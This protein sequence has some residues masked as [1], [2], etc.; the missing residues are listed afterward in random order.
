MTVRLRQVVVI[1]RDL[2]TTLDRLTTN[3][4][5]PEPFMKNVPSP[6]D[7][8]ILKPSQEPICATSVGLSPSLP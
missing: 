7:A 4:A 5:L 8:A 3:L 2:P 1:T 6:R